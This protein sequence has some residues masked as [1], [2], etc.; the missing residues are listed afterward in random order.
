MINFIIVVGDCGLLV[1][2]VFAAFYIL[3]KFFVKIG[4]VHNNKIIFDVI[5]KFLKIEKLITLNQWCKTPGLFPQWDS[6]TCFE[7]IRDV[8]NLRQS[9]ASRVL[10]KVW[11]TVLEQMTHKIRSKGRIHSRDL[12]WRRCLKSSQEGVSIHTLASSLTDVSTEIN[13]D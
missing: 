6:F 2:I 8:P 7:Y 12:F 13:R 1:I 10:Q 5:E 11:E 4:I 3:D 9:L